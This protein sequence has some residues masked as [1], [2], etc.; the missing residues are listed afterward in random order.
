MAMSVLIDDD[1]FM[2]ENLVRNE[3]DWRDWDC[4]KV[5]ALARK[6]ALVNPYARVSRH[7]VQLN[8]QA[9]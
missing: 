1:L 3:L 5:D 9:S 2:S 4:I 7:K 6:L 8:G